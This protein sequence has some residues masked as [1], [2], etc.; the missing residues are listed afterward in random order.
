MH[1]FLPFSPPASSFITLQYFRQILTNPATILSSVTRRADSQS[2]VE[3]AL[4]TLLTTTLSWKTEI[5]SLAGLTVAKERILAALMATS[6]LWSLEISAATTIATDTMGRSGRALRRWRVLSNMFALCA[7]NS[8]LL[9]TQ[10][11]QHV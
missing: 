8:T 10:T 11:S 1:F 5:S 6:G 4:I 9:F 2:F 7:I 3:D